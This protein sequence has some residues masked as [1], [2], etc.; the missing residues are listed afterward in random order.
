MGACSGRAPTLLWP[1]GVL[2]LDG[3]AIRLAEPRRLTQHLTGWLDAQTGPDG[4]ADRCAVRVQARRRT[5]A[6][7][8]VR[9]RR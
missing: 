5:R 7:G 1:T 6:V 9:T 3:A 8:G 4:A 2:D